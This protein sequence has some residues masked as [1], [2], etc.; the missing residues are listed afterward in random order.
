VRTKKRHG[1]MPDSVMH[2]NATAV[3]IV[4]N[5]RD[6]LRIFP[7]LSMIGCN[8]YSRVKSIRQDQEHAK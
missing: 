6:Q 7:H 4:A 3:V 1:K 8:E 2:K 5:D